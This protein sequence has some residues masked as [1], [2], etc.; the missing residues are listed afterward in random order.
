[1]EA[2]QAGPQPPGAPPEVGR[3]HEDSLAKRK[4]RLGPRRVSGMRG[5]GSLDWRDSQGGR[6]GPKSET[7]EP[8]RACLWLGPGLRGWL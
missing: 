1:M 4:S 3:R 2:E 8:R 5:A 6:A 7:R